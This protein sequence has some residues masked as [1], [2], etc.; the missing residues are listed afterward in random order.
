MRR[1]GVLAGIVAFVCLAAPAQAIIIDFEDLHKPD[2]S[3]TFFSH[4]YTYLSQGF[5]ISNSDTRVGL[6]LVWGFSDSRY[7]GSTALAPGW[8]STNTLKRTDAAAF[9]MTSIDLCDLSLNGSISAVVTF[10][11]TRADSST[12]TQSFTVDDG[13][14]MHTFA[15][16]G[17]TNIVRLD[18]TSPIHQQQFDNIV[19][20][21]QAVPEPI[22]M[23]LMG[24]AALAGSRR[25]RRKRSA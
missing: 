17:M 23:A 13:D 25:I 24:A 9:D 7:S 15:F 12:F 4:P 21:P 11:G 1:F 10:V 6:F 22:T 20:T 3:N 5:E 8:V 18:W 16:S 2:G 14:V 19:I